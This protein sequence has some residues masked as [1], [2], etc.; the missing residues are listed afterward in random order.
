MD[1]NIVYPGAIPLVQRNTMVALGFLMQAVFGASKVFDGLGISA[2]AVPDTFVHIAPGS[3]ISLSTIDTNAFGSLS[4]DSRALV[5]M[6]VNPSTTDINLAS[7]IPS[8]S[9]QSVVVVIEAAMQE[10]DGNAVVLPYYNSTN[11]AQPYS[12]PNNLGA[13]QPTT[14]TQA[15]QLRVI[16]GAPTSGTPSVPAVDAGFVGLYAITLTYNQNSITTGNLT[17]GNPYVSALIPTAPFLQFKLPQLRPGFG[18][19]TQSF[20]S[21]GTT[22]WTVPAG[23]TTCEVE[24]WGAG[25]GGGGGGANNAV[26]YNSGSGGGGG[27]Y[28][29]KRVAGLTPGNTVTITVGAGGAGATSYSGSGSSGGTSSFGAYASAT[30]GGGGAGGNNSSVPPPGVGGVGSGGDYNAD[31]S[32]GGYPV[33]MYYSTNLNQNPGF[34]GASGSGGGFGSPGCGGYGNDDAGAAP[35]GYGGT[36]AN[37][38]NGL[39]VIRW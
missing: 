16:S 5:K 38:S 9:G 37:G 29:R 7:Y 34:P 36:A 30:G 15:V 21:P 8:V 10:S 23:V 18:S 13:P 3:I 24:V 33:A 2:S 14:R 39:V 32:P 27:G 26:T 31:G 17:T 25:G 12:G 4:S 19:N 35:P 28:T 20:S 6:G 1:R 11:P 22:T